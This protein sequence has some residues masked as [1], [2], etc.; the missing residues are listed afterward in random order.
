V[1]GASSHLAAHCRFA[2]AALRSGPNPSCI[3]K[4]VHKLEDIH[5]IQLTFCRSTCVLEEWR[6]E[7]RCWAP[8]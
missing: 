1:K 4:E 6:S 2:K 3:F 7:A 8:F 5:P